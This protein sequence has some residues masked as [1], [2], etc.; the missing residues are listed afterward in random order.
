VSSRRKFS[1]RRYR[2]PCPADGLGCPGIPEFGNRV[3]PVIKSLQDSGITTYKGIADVLNT[4]G[5]QTARGG[6]W[7]ATTV[8]RIV[9]RHSKR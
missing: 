2:G 8:R 1:L 7:D 6:R 9:L 4:R 3:M 5:I